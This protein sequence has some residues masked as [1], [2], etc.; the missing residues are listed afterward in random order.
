MWGNSIK[1]LFT[2][3]VAGHTYTTVEDL[4]LWD[5]DMDYWLYPDFDIWNNPAYKCSE[6]SNKAHGEIKGK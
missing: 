2:I 1:R 4:P 5:A 3:K 6:H